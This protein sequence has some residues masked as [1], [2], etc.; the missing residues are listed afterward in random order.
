ML[1]PRL[2]CLFLL[3]I[4]NLAIAAGGIFESVSGS[5]RISGL[6]VSQ[7]Q[8]FSSGAKIQTGPNSNAVL[9]FEDNQVLVLNENTDIDISKYEYDASNNDG[10]TALM[11]VKGSLRYL[12]GLIAKKNPESF[13]LD[14]PVATVGIRGTDF[15]A[16]TG[17]LYIQVFQG[18][19]ILN[20]PA[21]SLTY[22]AGQ[23]GFVSNVAGAIPTTIGASQLPASVAAAFNN[24]AAVPI[25]GVSGLSGG[26]ST[27]GASTGIST[28]G[29]T[30]N[31]G[32]AVASSTAA[33]GGIT[34]TALTI[35]GIVV[36]VVVE[37][38]VN[39]PTGTTG[40]TGTTH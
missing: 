37:T 13:K 1:L 17:S 3:L 18:P 7:G 26:A 33:I 39:N 22:N 32:G 4:A 15:M 5:V 12:S 40:A 23:L 11:L 34:T 31:A 30:I 24:L 2:A 28:S 8:H 6:K 38:V 10:S 25:S 36:G 19:V 29:V 35:G 16:A 14:T 27:S 9:R 21:G 20:T